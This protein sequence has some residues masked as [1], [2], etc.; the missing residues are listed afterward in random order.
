MKRLISILTGMII[1]LCLSC[2][3]DIVPIAF[4]DDQCKECKMTISDP[5]FGA[6]IVTKKG[7]I[8][9]FDSVECLID[10]MAKN[11][12][13]VILHIAVVDYLN[14]K[15]LIDAREAG[16]LITEKIPSPMGGFISA[17]SSIEDAQ[18]Q[19]KLSEGNTYSLSLLRKIKSNPKNSKK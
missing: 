14:P 11:E 17:Y 7:K 9:K 18:I 5:R 3:T 12:E 1:I 13:S 4:G 8:Q 19:Q 15:N 6:E 2:K 10:Y 16:Y